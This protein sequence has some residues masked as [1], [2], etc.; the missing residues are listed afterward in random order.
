M[1][2]PRTFMPQEQDILPSSSSQL[3]LLVQMVSELVQQPSDALA[4]DLDI[5]EQGLDSVRLMLLV[6]R[7]RSRGADVDFLDMTQF[8]TLESWAALLEERGFSG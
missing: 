1:P 4:V 6:E 8:T 5:V 2:L 7:L 3:R